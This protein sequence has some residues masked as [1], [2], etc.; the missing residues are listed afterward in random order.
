[1]LQRGMYFQEQAPHSVLL[2]SVRTN[3]PYADEVREDGSLLIYEG[4]DVPT[5][6]D[7]PYPKQVDQP[8]FLPS[9]KPTENGKFYQAALDYKAGKSAARLVRVYEKIRTGIWSYNGM[10]ELV[11]AS[12]TEIE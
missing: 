2:M 1:M 7:N 11:D 10:F 12:I 9:G 8:Q 6:P 3:A 4:H 5:S